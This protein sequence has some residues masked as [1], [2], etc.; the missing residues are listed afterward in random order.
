MQNA[1]RVRAL[2]HLLDHFPHSLLTCQ[3]GV[4]ISSLVLGWLAEPA[5]A[6]LLLSAATGLGLVVDPG[7]PWLHGAA[8]GMALAV[9]TVLHM[10][11]G[12][13]VPKIWA[14]YHPETAGLRIAYPLRVFALVFWPF[15]WFLNN[16]S[17]LLLRLLGLAPSTPRE[18]S[19]SVEELKAILVTSAR[20]GHISRRQLEIAHNVFDHIHREVCHILVPLSKLVLL[21]TRKSI[22]VNLRIICD[23]GHSRFPLCADDLGSVTGIVHAKDVMRALARGEEPDLAKLARPPAFVPHRRTISRLIVGMQRSQQHCAVVLD[24]AGCALGLVF[25]EDAVEELLGPIADEFDETPGKRRLEVG[26]RSEASASASHKARARS[27]GDSPSEV[28]Q[29][30]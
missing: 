15:I 26:A 11:A 19:A 10:T 21:S 22:A 16:L 13:Q 28:R 9:V 1:H 23:S 5:V 27:E 7:D 14:I 6:E 17:S 4:T 25:L 24:E 30:G 18:S 12:E 29:P 8:V 3:L 2:E 20:A